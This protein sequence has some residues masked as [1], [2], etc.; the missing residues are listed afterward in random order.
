MPIPVILIVRDGFQIVKMRSPSER[1]ADT[2][3]SPHDVGWIIC[4]PARLARL[5]AHPQL[6]LR[7]VHLSSDGP[8]GH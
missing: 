8:V 2:V 1:G 7:G 5:Q 6:E 3:A 4:P